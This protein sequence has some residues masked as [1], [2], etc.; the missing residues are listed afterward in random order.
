MSV[1]Q[2]N[3]PLGIGELFF[4]RK[5]DTSGKYM[6]VGVLKGAVNFVYEYDTVEQKPGNRLTVARR[7]KVAERAYLTAQV[8]DLKMSQLIPALGLSI[9]T[10]QLTIT[11][12]LRQVEEI[13]FTSITTTKTLAKTAVSTTSVVAQSLARG[14]KFV[15]GTDFTVPSTT[16]VKPILAGFANRSNLVH[17]DT[18][19]VSATTTRVGDKYT[20]QEVD[21]KFMHKL[22]NGKFIMVEMPIATITGG[23]TLPFGETE[24]TTYNVRFDAVGDMTVAAGRSLFKIVRQS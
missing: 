6:P 1:Q 3:I 20:L 13:A 21:L 19:N 7:D 15:K 12:T 23:L 8:M 5:D 24:Y 9:S 17:Y 22:S 18:K 16:K 10:T 2:E 14:T 4:K 11:S